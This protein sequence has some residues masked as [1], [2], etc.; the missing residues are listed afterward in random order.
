MF[1]IYPESGQNGIIRTFFTLNMSFIPLFL[2]FWCTNFPPNRTELYW[3]SSC[4]HISKYK[5]KFSVHK[6]LGKNMGNRAFFIAQLKCIKSFEP[7]EVFRIDFF[8]ILDLVFPNSSL[9]FSDLLL[10]VLFLNFIEI[11]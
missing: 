10:N 5:I 6:M 4:W 11:R 7:E 1:S 9:S 8:P 3:F 2:G